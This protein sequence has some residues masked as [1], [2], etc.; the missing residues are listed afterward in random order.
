MVRYSP[1]MGSISSLISLQSTCVSVTRVSP[2]CFS[3]V[4]VIV[5]SSISPLSLSLNAVYMSI[6]PSLIE[7]SRG[8]ETS[9]YS[10]ASV[11]S[12]SID[13]MPM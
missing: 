3:S 5:S 6:S 10:H 7:A 2:S 1:G 11:Y 9:R 4:L 8:F 12:P 13:A